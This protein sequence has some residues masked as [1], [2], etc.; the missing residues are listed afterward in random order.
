MSNTDDPTH[1][2]TETYTNRGISLPGLRPTRQRIGLTQRQLA[3][4]ANLFALRL[5]QL[6]LT[7]CC[8][9]H[10]PRSVSR[11][12]PEVECYPGAFRAT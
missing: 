1:E 10:C 5:S 9:G 7:I 3:S 6:P 8:V 4:L 12:L 11:N 2:P